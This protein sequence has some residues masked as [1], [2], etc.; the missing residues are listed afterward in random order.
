VATIDPYRIVLADDHVILRQGL[1]MVLEQKIDLQV[2]G[3]V[4][5]GL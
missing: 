1:K 2:V 4:G 3:E 5:D